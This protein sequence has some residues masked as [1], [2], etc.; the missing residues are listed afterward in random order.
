MCCLES[1]PGVG[2]QAVGA[3]REVQGKARQTGHQDRVDPLHAGLLRFRRH[4]RCPESGGDARVLRLV[5]HAGSGADPK[6]AGLRRKELRNSDQGRSGLSAGW[7]TAFLPT[8]CPGNRLRQFVCACLL[9]RSSQA[10]GTEASPA[11]Q[12]TANRRV[13]AAD[14]LLQH[15]VFLLEHPAREIME[16]RGDRARLQPSF[17]WVR[18]ERRLPLDCLHSG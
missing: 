1:E 6:Y 11:S 16:G 5:L 7:L 3:R 9:P 17:A 2:K 18:E 8:T 12:R 14:P 13:S 15:V 4:R 10:R